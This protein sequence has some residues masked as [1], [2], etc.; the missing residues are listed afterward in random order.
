MNHAKLQKRRRRNRSDVASRRGPGTSKS[1]NQTRMHSSAKKKDRIEPAVIAQ[2]KRAED[3]KHW[4]FR[5][6]YFKSL[7]DANEYYFII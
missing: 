5:G 4:L 7:R 3:G 2:A 6:E 1:F